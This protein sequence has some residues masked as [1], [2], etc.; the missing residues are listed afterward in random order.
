MESQPQVPGFSGYS[1]FKDVSPEAV[2]Y[3]RKALEQ[4][5]YAEK[6]RLQNLESS[7]LEVERQRLACKTWGIILAVIVAIPVVLTITVALVKGLLS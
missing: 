7:R 2:E 3:A 1:G 5:G 6:A 4:A